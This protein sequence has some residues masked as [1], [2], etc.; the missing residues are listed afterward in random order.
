MK[1]RKSD[2]EILVMCCFAVYLAYLGRNGPWTPNH[3]AGTVLIAAGY[4]GWLIARLQIREFFTAR[5]EARGLVT[6]GIYSKI[7][8]PIYFF[9]MVILVGIVLYG[10]MPWWGLLLVLLVILMQVWRARN[11]ARVLEAKFG[12]TYRQY[13]AKT[14]F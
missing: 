2:L 10:S 12:D 3:I 14:W 13:R 7:R 6:T 1:L 8:N 5:A 4:V 11:E 9:G